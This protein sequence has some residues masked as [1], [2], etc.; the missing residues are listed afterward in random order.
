LKGDEI[1][2]NPAET[3]KRFVQL[4]YIK[5]DMEGGNDISNLGALLFANDITLFPSISSKSVRVIKLRARTKANLKERS[6]G[7]R[8]MPL[9]FVGC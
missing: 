3:I 7:K 6:K 9:D 8:V 5:E 1:P 2:K 4:G